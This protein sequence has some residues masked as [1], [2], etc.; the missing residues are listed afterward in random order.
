MNINRHNYEEFFLLY[1]DN[2]LQ[3]EERVQVEQFVQQNPDLANELEML[4]Q[5]TLGGDEVTFADKAG[6]YKTETG[7][8]VGNYQEFFLSAI[9]NELTDDEA[10]S[11]E[12]FILKHPELQDEF[13]LLKQTQLQPEVVEYANKE[14]LYRKGRKVVPLL[15]MRVAA[16]AAVLAIVA[17]TWV[18]NTGKEDGQT[19]AS[20]NTTK[21]TRAKTNATASTHATAH[22]SSV[23]AA[24]STVTLPHAASLNNKPAKKQMDEAV[25]KQAS[26]K[27][28]VAPQA[29]VVT[30]PVYKQG[31]ESRKE[32]AQ[33]SIATLNSTPQKNEVI[34]APQVV[35]NNTTNNDNNYKATYAANDLTQQPSLASHAVYLDTDDANSE[36]RNVYIGGAAINK[37]KLKGIFKKAS[38]LFRRKTNTE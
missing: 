5:A 29:P 10:Q 22:Q 31:V 7:V 2:E 1:V 19:T 23:N 21:P 20:V 27:K 38:T 37:N 32:D 3:Q 12:Q 18:F 24:A 34:E 16:A 11:L 25:A 28:D 4:Q 14:E 26:V 13:I 33:Q 35:K 17:A 6:L 8:T 15:W 30:A 9:D 36:D